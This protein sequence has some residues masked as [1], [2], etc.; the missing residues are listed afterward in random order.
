MSK[1]GNKVHELKV[2]KAYMTEIFE[3]RKTFEVRK[4][5]RDFMVNDIL[6]LNEVDEKGTYT[7]RYTLMKITYIL[8]DAQYCKDGYVVMAIKPR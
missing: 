4:K 1:R 7:G 8:D 6:A 5:D 3:Q 2:C